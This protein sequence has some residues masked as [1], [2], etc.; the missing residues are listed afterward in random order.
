MTT[1]KIDPS[2]SEIHFKVK[3]LMIS[4]VTGSF[5]KFDASMETNQ[6][7]F[8]DAKIS[9]SAET[10]SIDTNDERRDGHLQSADFFDAANHPKISFISTSL[11]KKGEGE[12]EVTGDLTVKDITKI[13][14]LKV[15]HL[16]TMTDGYGQ[17]KAGFEVEGKINR[18]DWNLGWNM[19][20]NNGGLLVSDE[21]KLI[22]NVQMTK[23]VDLASNVATVKEEAVA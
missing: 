1:Y 23:Q 7:D 12:F 22:L 15:T 5:K 3:H 9:F 4:T 8:S 19:P 2:H 16:G 13:A 10:S 20:M 18:K 17:T 6:E 11:I 14:T 21:V